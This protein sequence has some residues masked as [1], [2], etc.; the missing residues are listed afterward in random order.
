MDDVAF[1]KDPHF[2]F[3]VPVYVPALA[4]AGIDQ[5]ILDPRSTWADEAEYDATARKLVQLFIDN[6]SQFE[7]HVDE[8]VRQAA[9]APASVAA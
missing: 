1:R 6:F 5:T 3:D 7:A 2:G 4:E 8:A 9:P